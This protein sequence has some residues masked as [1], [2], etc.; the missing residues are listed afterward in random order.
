MII[1]ITGTPGTGKTTLSKKISKK[2]NFKYI[3]GNT[4]IK[5]YSLIEGYDTIKKCNI[6]DE[7]KFSKSVT[8]Y[9][10]PNE[11]YIIDS[12]LSHYIDSTKVKLCIVC[13]CNLKTL[14]KR[15]KKRKY[16]KQK[17]KDNLECEIFETCLNEAITNKHKIIVSNNL[18]EISKKIKS[19]TNKN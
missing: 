15:L 10:K 5:K 12:H 9:C 11:N 6:V 19:I 17:I 4:I 14:E 2:L 3:S 7:I 16:S 1:I 13:K 18:Q 8:K